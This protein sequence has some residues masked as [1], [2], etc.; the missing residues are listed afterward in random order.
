[1]KILHIADLHLE[2]GYNRVGNEKNKLL[3]E[4]G[5][6]YFYQTLEIAKNEQ[7]SA[8]LLC[9]DLFDKLSVRVSTRKEI[10]KQISALPD[11]K[12]FYCLGNHDHKL[13]FE[14]EK[15]ENLIIFSTD[16]EKYE[17]G[18]VVIGGSSVLKFSK[19]DFVDKIDFEKGKLNILML[20]A[21]LSAS[22]FDDC[23]SF[24]V[25]ELKNKNID[26]LAL[27]HVHTRSDGKIDDRGIW[28]YSG[29]GGKYGFGNYPRGCV[30]INIDGGK[31]TWER[32]DFKQKR[33]F[34]DVQTDISD[35][36]DS[37][38]IEKAISLSLAECKK[39]DFVRVFLKGEYDEEIYKNIPYLID[40]FGDNYFYFD[41][42]DDSKL[43]IDIERLQYETL[44]LK[45]ELIKLVLAADLT[46]EEKEKCIKLG[47]SALRGEEVDV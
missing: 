16:F 43:R 35:C 20:H 9:G 47:V 40:K 1:M 13:L 33:R 2:G 7:V 29:N 45:A 31:I 18:D 17:L 25:K 15:P 26:Y 39:T 19:R 12:F 34:I 10:L 37:K 4:E 3:K 5:L 46:D 32:R 27:G 14:D 23:L 22:K 21:Y 41:I 44:S 11:I 38:D 28:V 30:I 8:V 42:R 36:K 24:E 6:D